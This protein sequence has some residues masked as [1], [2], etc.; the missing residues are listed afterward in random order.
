MECLLVFLPADGAL[1]VVGVL[2]SVVS[3]TWLAEDHML[4][5][6][7]QDFLSVGKAEHAQHFMVELVFLC[8]RLLIQLGLFV[9]SLF[10]RIGLDY[11]RWGL[12]L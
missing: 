7:N 5:G 3:L 10:L 1:R 9:L 8:G 6:L 11:L 2:E 4:A 12:A